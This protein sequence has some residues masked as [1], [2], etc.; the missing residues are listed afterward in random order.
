MN[1]KLPALLATAITAQAVAQDMPGEEGPAT[2]PSLGDGPREIR[3]T[4]E[5]LAKRV[6]RPATRMELSALDAQP[7]LDEDAARAAATDEKSDPRVAVV[8]AFHEV[9]APKRFVQ[10]ARGVTTMPD[11]S[12]VWSAQFNA[13]GAIG[14]R[15]HV[16]ACD[17][18]EGAGVVVLDV[19][20]PKQAYG[21]FTGDGP[22]GTGEFYLPTVFADAVRVELRVPPK[23]AGEP[24][25]FAIDATA[26][27]YRERGEGLAD[28][29]VGVAAKS[30][31]CNNDIACDASYLADVARG[32]ATMEMTTDRGVFLCTGALLRD[33][34]P[35]TSVPYFLTAHHC[36]STSTVAQNTEF[37]FDYRSPTCGGTPPSLA[38]VP[39]VHGAALIATSAAT[40]FTL[41][42]LTGTM[43]SNRFFCGWTAARQTTGE[44]VVGVHHPGGGR[45]RISYGALLEPSGGFHYVQWSSGVTAPGSSGSPLFN[46]AKQ[47]IGQLY[48]GASSCS[49]QSGIDEYGRFDRTYTSIAT[50]LGTGSTG[51]TTDPSDPTDDKLSG[52]SLLV[53]DVSGGSHGPHLL[54]KND[55]VD[56][57]VFD[58]QAGARYRIFSTGD[59]DVQAT[60]YADAGATTVAVSDQDS[61]GS[62]Q[63]SIDFT[64][65]V[66]GHY[67]LKVTAATSGAAAGYTL[68]FTR[69]DPSRTRPPA[70]VL[71]LRKAVRDTLAI[72]KWKDDA[73]TESGYFVDLSADGGSNWS[74]I[75]ELP[76]GAQTFSCI[77][78]S[79]P[80]VLRVG[81][82]NA[83]SL[84]TTP[85]TIKWRKIKL[86]IV[87]VNEL[88]PWDNADDDSAGATTLTPPAR[89]ASPPHTLSRSDFV[90]WYRIDLEAGTEYIVE[91]T[92]AADTFGDLFDDAAG[93][94]R[95]ASDDDSGRGR[96]F[97]ITVK[98]PRTGTY[99]VRVR[100]YLDGAVMTY[101]LKWR[102]R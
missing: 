40:D 14:L 68:Q 55:V 84:A 97:R 82:W 49:L 96:N 38:S 8:R 65:P 71:N 73:R 57:F 52:A 56:W 87:D 63:F 1:W 26:Q 16:S 69:V 47:I 20:D 54:S 95:E 85:P 94:S 45:M 80:R 101:V 43:P 7:L 53:P 64:P 59:D 91:T 25:S 72:L 46:D 44:A 76:R 83:A 41:L 27:R 67:P 32:V 98:A 13:V 19:A 81:A 11:G 24:V 58:L 5:L 2:G 12:L 28:P 89:G 37:Y 29:R 18:P 34:D 100:P 77:P 50:F 48:G 74:R 78:G 4:A 61:A 79:G 33:S 39:R 99:W 90:D 75:G 60:L 93:T 86:N 102:R 9:R 6:V 10:R 88:D 66:T 30:G 21:P 23:S 22:K 36:L 70:P 31:D 92:G 42:K 35:A 62:G 3:T 17:L 15:L 51:E